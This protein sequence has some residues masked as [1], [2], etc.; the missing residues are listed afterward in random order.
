MSNHFKKEAYIQK[1][2]TQKR[3]ENNVV[4]KEKKS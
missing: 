4:L 2:K 1:T 3:N